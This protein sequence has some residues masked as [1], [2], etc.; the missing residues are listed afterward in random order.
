VA[1]DIEVSRLLKKME[2]DWDQR[3]RENAR[4]YIVNSRADWTEDEFYRGGEQAVANDVLTDM[5]NICQGKYPKQMKV[6]DIGCG[7]GRITRALAGV[8]GEAHGVDVSGE[9]IALAR[10]GCAGVPNAFFY[11]NNG[12]DLAVVGERNFDF[13]FSTLCFHH[14]SSREVIENY[15]REVSRLLRPGGLFKFE[16]QGWVELESRPG[17]TWFGVPF[18]D[19]QAVAMAERCGFEPRYRVGAGEEDF[20]LWFFKK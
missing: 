13:A 12:M 7:A 14:I 19:E 2:L 11:Q 1:D 6:L 17:D 15:V 3:A 4:Y 16:V 10:A 18:S 20:W 5:V 8:F 9:M